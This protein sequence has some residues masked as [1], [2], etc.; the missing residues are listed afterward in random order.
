MRP[1]LEGAGIVVTRPGGA[2]D[3]LATLL[4]ADG[5]RVLP[6]PALLI[7][8]RDEPAPAEPFDAV[9]FTS[10]A[11]VHHGAPRLGALP[12]MRLAPGQSTREALTGAGIGGVFAPQQGAGLAALLAELTATRLAGKRLL[13]VCGEPVNQANIAALRERDAEP[14]VFVAYRRVPVREAQPLDEWLASGAVDVIMASSTAAVRAMSTLANIDLRDRSW[15]ASS[16]RVAE[17]IRSGGGRIA[18]TA[19]SAEALDMRAAARDWWRQQESGG[20]P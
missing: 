7:T 1:A 5:A 4:E 15:I 12:P 6:F 8:R 9:L 20:R 17:A 16:E 3:R 14:V 19:A 10:P 18:T 13:V 11:A 2:R